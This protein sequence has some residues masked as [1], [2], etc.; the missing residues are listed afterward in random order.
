MLDSYKNGPES[1]HVKHSMRDSRTDSI[2]NILQQ[3]TADDAITYKSKYREQQT[4][5]KSSTNVTV[6]A[7]S[8]KT[9]QIAIEPLVNYNI[10]TVKN[11]LYKSSKNRGFRP[12]L[13]DFPSHQVDRA[14]AHSFKGGSR[15]NRDLGQSKSVGTA[16]LKHKMQ[17]HLKN[18]LLTPIK[19]QALK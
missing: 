13:N 2:G 15:G 9:N 12:V 4:T 17:S 5:G 10:S 6:G 14:H 3:S 19:D 16:L 11:P 8:L 7:Q 1:Q 18:R